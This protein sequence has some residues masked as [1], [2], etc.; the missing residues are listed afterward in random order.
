MELSTWLADWTNHN[1]E[2]AALLEKYGRT[3]IPLYL[4][5]SANPN[6]PPLILPQILTK[7]AVIDALQSVSAKKTEVASSF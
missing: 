7:S 1:A 6:E 5:Y 3:G 2:I 4:M